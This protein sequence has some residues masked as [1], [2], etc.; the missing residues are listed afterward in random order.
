MSDHAVKKNGQCH[1]DCTAC[2]VERL[3][4]E[5][6]SCE[7]V[8]DEFQQK[9]IQLQAVVDAALAHHDAEVAADDSVRMY[10]A[11]KAFAIAVRDFRVLGGD[12]GQPIS[13]QEALRISTETLL[14]AEAE[15][16]LDGGEPWDWGQWLDKAHELGKSIPQEPCPD[17]ADG[18]APKGGN[19]GS[20]RYICPTCGGRGYFRH[21]N[22]KPCPTCGGSG[23]LPTDTPHTD[24]D[25]PTCGGTGRYGDPQHGHGMDC[26]TCYGTGRK[27]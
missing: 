7:L 15:R 13:R 22:W 8:M 27:P 21:E 23:Y 2:H 17:C 25:C 19:E 1:D 10:R 24:R 3:T 18:I 20:T 26:P 6:K 14:R 4:A 5:L 9:N 11:W 16:A 12:P